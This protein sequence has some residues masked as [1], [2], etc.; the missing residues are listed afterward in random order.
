MKRKTNA[1]GKNHGLKGRNEGSE[2]SR[3]FKAE[4]E[5]HV[6]RSYSVGGVPILN[7]FLDRLQIAELLDE[8]LP[9]RDKRTTMPAST[10]LLVLVRN[11]LIARQPIYGVREWAGGFAPNLLNV[12]PDEIGRLGDDRLGRDLE[13]FFEHCG[14]ALI[15][16]VVRQVVQEFQVSLDE[17]H[18]DSTT[19]SFYGAYPAAEKEHRGRGRPT[20][21][22]TWGHSKDH[23]PDL[24]QLL[25]TLTISDDGGVPVYFTSASGNVVDDQT[26]QQTWEMLRQLAGGPDFLYVADCK[27]ATTDNMTYI[28]RHG[29]RFVSV[30]PRTRKE[31]SEFRQRLREA[32]QS[33]RWQHL[34]DVSDEKDRVTDRLSTCADEAVSAEGFRLLWYHSTRKAE[35]DAAARARSVQRALAELSELRDRLTG[36]RT[37][38]RELSKVQEAVQEILQRFEVESWVTVTIEP[39]EQ[40]EYR[41]AD[42]G[43]PSKQTRY[44]KKTRTRYTLSWKINL[45]RLGEAQGDDGV[46]PLISNDLELDTTSL[47]RA[48]K[49]QP[50]IEKRFSQLKT[51]FAVAPVYLKCAARVQGLLAVYFLALLVQAL[52][53]REL[54]QAMAAK[55]IDSLALYPEER[56]CARP[57]TARVLELFAPIQ[58]HELSLPN[59]EVVEMVTELSPVQRKILRLLNLPEST[60]GYH[61]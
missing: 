16:A 59:G 24:K 33:V 23:R 21:A 12:W 39:L 2:V 15:L 44:I 13:R 49:R 60:Y 37:R 55:K 58:R 43:R 35:R 34:Y 41:Q 19:I 26:H 36:P 25:Y 54:R 22:I 28:A 20:A 48:Y 50:V 51:D 27:L 10:T 61:T 38:F 56:A 30:M 11:I 42:R 45:E 4:R 18:N 14:P 7:R 31:D 32:P 29:G 5:G 47:L 46:F 57:T 40:S 1:A 9:A 52:L 6:L 53:E 3:G 8:H 17:L